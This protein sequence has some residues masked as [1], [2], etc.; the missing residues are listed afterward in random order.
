MYRVV[1]DEHITRQLDTL[2]VPAL[3]AFAELRVAL[4]L[5]PWAGRAVNPAHP[6]GPVRMMTFGP[7]G[8]GVAAFLILDGQRR[9]DIVQITWLA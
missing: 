8:E 6:D 3:R 5:D 2:P 1:T 7:G 9:V 4:E